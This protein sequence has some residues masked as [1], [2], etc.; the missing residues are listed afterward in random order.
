MGASAIDRADEQ[1]A[2]NVQR[3]WGVGAVVAH[4]AAVAHDAHQHVGRAGMPVRPRASPTKK[5]DGR[6]K[7]RGLRAAE[8]TLVRTCEG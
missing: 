2:V 3:V 8:T 5:D 1:A 7:G 6:Q 4:D